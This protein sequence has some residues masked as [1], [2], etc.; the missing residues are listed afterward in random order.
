MTVAIA[1]AAIG[2]KPGPAGAGWSARA[3]G[4]RHQMKTTYD[5]DY[6]AGAAPDP[7]VVEAMAGLP[8]EADANPNSP[9]SIGRKADAILEEARERL[10]A[11]LGVC[12]DEVVICSG[13]TEA[14]N[15][16]VAIA[17]GLE[18]PIAST[19]IEHASL[20]AP[21][22]RLE[23]RGR[24]VQYLA[25]DAE[26]RVEVS[27]IG[28]L[29]SIE[30]R[31]LAW[32]SVIH[33]HHELGVLQDLAA[34]RAALPSACLLHS[35]L[36]QS[37]GRVDVAATLEAL[38]YATL[39]PHKFGGPRGVGVFLARRG[40]PWSPVLVGGAQELGRRPGTQSPR[41][42][43][44]AALALELAINERA[45]RADAM[46]R[47]LDAFLSGLSGSDFEVVAARA[48]ELPN[49]ATLCFAPTEARRLLPA[50]DL[51]GICVS[52]GSAC[53]SGSREV[54]PSL[55]AIGMSK[56]RAACCLRVSVDAD[57]GAQKNAEAAALFSQVLAR[58]RAVSSRL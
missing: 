23:S 13:G 35:D 29:A 19:R 14:N 6:N 31:E 4:A 37:I 26:A 58:I 43:F 2:C 9:H 18:G 40:R 5:L 53:S 57:E 24:R 38:D 49:T 11:S 8:R 52:Y 42:A 56:E 51:A 55:I 21:L 46:R 33:A 12:A 20:S 22:Q 28:Q 47:K 45:Q 3:A 50:L 36:S 17:E 1:I 7:R 44:G 25:V 48:R 27:A 32:C 16:A 39:S 54:S 41:A 15:I 30:G 10:A 34:I